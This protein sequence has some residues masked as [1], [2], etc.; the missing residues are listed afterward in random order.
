[1]IEVVRDG[2]PVR[3]ERR[4]A[5]ELRLNGAAQPQRR[6]VEYR[7]KSDGGERGGDRARPVRDPRRG[8]HSIAH[9]LQQRGRARHDPEHEE[10][11][12]ARRVAQGQAGRR[13]A[14]G[15]LER[16]AEQRRVQVRMRADGDE[17]AGD[18][19][20]DAVRAHSPPHEKRTG[21][22]EHRQRVREHDQ[23]E[24]LRVVVRR[25]GPRTDP[26]TAIEVPVTEVAPDFG[27]RRRGGHRLNGLGE[28]QDRQAVA[29]LH[30]KP[31]EPPHL[32]G[33]R[34]RP[35]ATE[36]GQRTP[37]LDVAADPNRVGDPQQ[38]AEG[39]EDERTGVGR[40]DQ[41]HDQCQG[42]RESP[43]AFA[44]AA[45]GQADEPRET[46]N[47]QEQHRR[48]PEVHESI[49]TQRVE[50]ASHGRRATPYSPQA[51]QPHHAERGEEQD[52]GEPEALGDPRGYVDRPEKREPRAH[53]EEVADVLMGDGAEPGRLVPHLAHPSEHPER[54]Q[55]EEL[56][57][58]GGDLARAGEEQGHVADGSHE[59][60][61]PVRPA[62]GRSGGRHRVWR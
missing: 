52:R 16:G 10:R 33:Q 12:G 48:S 28:L 22:T 45:H 9:R 15:R 34:E 13:R 11:N 60:V 59:P 39:D 40:A 18:H 27:R 6:R 4:R 7:Q 42:R 19:E 31:D 36:R 62:P 54:I 58:V 53:R 26:V 55:V 41:G 30:T 14:G 46:R 32:R 37:P 24:P 49:R 17:R 1:M 50:E 47:R 3:G 25:V 43:A 56:L 44:K 29:R 57:G 51:Q 23:P 20:H 21:D 8:A 35:D 61:V 5:L 38:R 2:R